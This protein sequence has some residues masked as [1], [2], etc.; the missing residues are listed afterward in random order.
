MSLKNKV[1]VITGASKGLG[2]ALAEV[3]LS[4]G[5]KVTICSTNEQE[6]KSIAKEIGALGFCAD[7]TKEEDMTQLA[8]ATIKKFGSID[9][10]INNAGIWLPHNFVENFDMSKVRKMFDVNIVG[11]INGTRVALRHMKEK[12]SGTIIQ[13]IS[14]SALVGRPKST[15]YSASKWA[16]NGFTKGIREENKNISIL[17]IYPGGMKTYIF[18]ENKPKNF[19]EMMNAKDVAKKVIANLKLEK[20]EEELI[21]QKPKT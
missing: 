21:I 17:S 9:I 20:P 13:I 5:S 4:E 8:E 2:R 3:F 14:D 15:A 7:V 19:A 18:S 6:I 16:V 1:V 11:T 12:D 10:W